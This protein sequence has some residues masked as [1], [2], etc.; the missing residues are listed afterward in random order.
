MAASL[1]RGGSASVYFIDGSLPSLHDGALSAALLKQRFRS[2]EDAASEEESVGWVS[3]ADPSGDSFVVSE[4]ELEG[5]AGLWLQMRIDRKRLP[6][7]WVGIRRI[8]AEREAGRRL[9]GKERKELKE[10]LADEL[11]PRILPTVQVVDVLIDARGQR[12]LLFAGSRGARE[13]F[14]KLFRNTFAGCDLHPADA[15]E[16]ARRRRL[17]DEQREMLEEVAPVPWPRQPAATEGARR[18]AA[19]EQEASA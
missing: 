4:I 1:R 19:R 5:E 3:P 11:L 17:D 16:L 13:A 6:Q 7:R 2:I 9:S 15:Y 12:A 14:A 18:P 10:A 8:A